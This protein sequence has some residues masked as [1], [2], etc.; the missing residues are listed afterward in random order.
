MF[1][2]FF[3]NV[4]ST[5]KT[6]NAQMSCN[7]LH[8]TVPWHFIGLMDVTEKSV[9]HGTAQNKTEIITK[10]SKGDNT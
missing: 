4:S 10:H 5:A 7:H 1:R 2:T 8:H 6:A 3:L 9:F